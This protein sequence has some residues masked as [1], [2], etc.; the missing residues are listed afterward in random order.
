M[1]HL[2]PDELLDAI[3]AAVP[4]SRRAHLDACELC[5]REVMELATTLRDARV[6]D[7]PEPSPLFWDLFSHR[8]HQAVAAETPASGSTW[9][10]WLQ[11]PVLAPLAAMAL[12]VFALTNAV[13]VTRQDTISPGAVAD[14]VVDADESWALVPLGAAEQAVLDLTDAEQQE[15]LRL[16]EQE[17]KGAGS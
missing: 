15:L 9:P 17:L 12:V 3:E 14:S 4:E 16:L 6:V 7:I 5:R 13:H 2:T 8:V 1:N 11:W 10:S